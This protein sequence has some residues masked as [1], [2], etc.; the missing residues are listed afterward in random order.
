MAGTSR[1]SAPHYALPGNVYETALERIRWVFD[2]FDDQVTVS[3]SGG[4]D[5]TVV[6]ELALIVA[7]ERDALPVR[8]QWLDQEC[9]FEATVDYQTWLLTERP[10]EVRPQWLQIPFKLFNATNHQDEWLHVW[11]PDP[12]VE[13]VREKHPA[14][15]HESTIGEGKLFADI[16]TAINDVNGGAVLTGVRAEE[17][18]TRRLGLTTYPSYKWVTWGQKKSKLHHV[19]H[20]IFDWS[21]RDIWKAIIDGNNPAEPGSDPWRYN[22]HYDEMYRYGIPVQKMRVSNYHHE[23]A[24]SSLFYLQEIEPETWERATRR[25]EGISTA[26]QLGKDDFYVTEL[27][28]MFRS[29]EEYHGYLVDNIVPDPAHQATFRKHYADLVRRLP[30]TDRETIAK[31]AVQAVIANDLYFT[32]GNNFY[33]TQRSKNKHAERTA[34]A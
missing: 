20:P 32:K 27:P 14:A 33:V 7:R 3:I 6:L 9:E 13:W 12:A 5:S 34:N 1:V 22:R 15:I 10:D 28:F 2:E 16:L 21:W 4:K 11:D 24:I 31:H 18:P 23:T 26:G 30:G 8:A 17:S 19:F 29:W 25:L